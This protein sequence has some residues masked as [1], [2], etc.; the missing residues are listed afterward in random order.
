MSTAVAEPP[1]P[2]TPPTPPTPPPVPAPPPVPTPAPEPTPP[3]ETKVS[4]D[5]FI[6]GLLE[7][8][9]KLDT[10]PAAAATPPAPP[11][12]AP[13]PPPTPAPAPEPPKKVAVE[14]SKPINEIVES[15]VRKVLGENQ[16][17]S[18]PSPP[19]PA[20]VPVA[21]PP[22]EYEKQLGLAEKETLSIARF[23]AE[24]FPE[25][26]E[27]A[28]Q[29]LEFYKTVDKYVETAKV[30]DA[31]RTFDE[32]DEQFQKFIKDNR[33]DI[34]P[35]TWRQLE[36]AKIKEEAKTEAAKEIDEK[37]KAQFD[38]TRHKQKVLETRPVIEKK[39]GSFQDNVGRLM[40]ADANSPLAEI[41]TSIEKEGLDAVMKKDQLFAPI[42][43]E[44]YQNG[45]MNAAEWLVISHGLAQYDPNN[46]RH[47]WLA[48]FI[49]RQGDIFAEKGGDRTIRTATDG[50]KLTFMPRGQYMKLANEKPEEAAKH[51]TF[52]EDDVLRMLEANTKMAAE[53]RVKEMN[54]RLSSSGFQRPKPA[55]SAPP[56]SNNGNSEPEPP[57][58]PTT[59]PAAPSSASPGQGKGGTVGRNVMS[60]D[61]LKSLGLPVMR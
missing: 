50:S 54:D 47:V 10:K 36:S 1:K 29:F 23:A 24:K 20:P 7:D 19:T 53:K 42:V 31:E 37:Y 32:S 49:R 28:G 12:P 57:P 21:S 16:P 34:D 26:K 30:T 17:I 25:Y 51:W 38:E 14:K 48:G 59:S 56:V 4:D 11:V 18:T 41:A 5:P 46:Q 52:E 2:S 27:L 45:A 55:P 6:H 9:G 40:A 33:P 22:D 43:V 61:E 44:E 15:T 58:V 35:V 39:L 13:T 60:D 8:L 3:V